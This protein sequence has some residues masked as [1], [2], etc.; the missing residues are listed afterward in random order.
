[1]GL[2]GVVATQLWHHTFIDAGLAELPSLVQA[3]RCALNGPP[4]LAVS[5]SEK[6][7]APESAHGEAIEEE[8]LG[9]GPTSRSST[10]GNDRVHHSPRSG[11]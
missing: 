10:T 7:H 8:T 6:S 2:V 9:N 4:R 1:M 5:R 11:E 3:G